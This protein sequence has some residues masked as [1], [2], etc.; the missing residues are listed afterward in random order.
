MSFHTTYLS[1]WWIVLSL[2]GK[3]PRPSLFHSQH[4]VSL[5]A[6]C[7][8]ICISLLDKILGSN[9]YI[10][11]GIH[12]S[13]TLTNTNISTL[14]DTLW[15]LYTR[16]WN[17]TLSL[18]IRGSELY[19]LRKCQLC[20]LEVLHSILSSS[21]HWWSPSTFHMYP[22]RHIFRFRSKN[23]SH[24]IARSPIPYLN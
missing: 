16:A 6:L 10:R 18:E 2:S 3:L 8:S 11:L 7:Y 23:L 21:S 15:R 12:P 13:Q 1:T 19:S 9:W 24:D 20:T 5:L 14:I 22:R 17:P 4:I